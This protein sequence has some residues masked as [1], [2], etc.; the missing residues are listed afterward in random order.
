M[1]EFG[2]YIGRFQPFH[3][4]HLETVRFALKQAKKL[5]IVIGSDNQARTI[6]NPWTS[7]ERIAMMK[8]AISVS[9][10]T[11]LYTQ[12]KVDKDSIEPIASKDLDDVLDR[13]IFI[14]A[15]DYLYN[16]NLWIAAV[17]QAI[18]T[19][20][21]GSKDVVLIGHKKDES[22]FYLKLFPQWKFMETD[23]FDVHCDATKIRDMMF[24][25]DKISFKDR[26]PYYVYNYLIN[27]MDGAEFKRLKEEYDHIARYRA[28]WADAPHPPMFV[29]TDAVVI[30]SGHILVVRRKGAPG[31]GL[32]ALPGGFLQQ[33]E[34]IVDGCIR[35]L[36]EE[37]GIKLPATD[38]K[39]HIVGEH[40][41][42]HPHRSLRGRTI[43]HAFCIKLKD[44]EL[45]IVK[46]MDDADKAWWVPLR[47]IFGHE[48][49]FF[50]DHFHIITYFTH[51]F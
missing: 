45:P 42:D 7:E 6:N 2:I 11:T 12:S 39:T 1:H 20:T 31:Q 19:V 51:R 22:S 17:Q 48:N 38:L 9:A 33:E 43:T 40:V 47:D 13:I 24:M 23:F 32:I 14:T 36:K 3:N 37:T 29:T 8:S 49:E 35:E 16:E 25:Q 28:D 5:I 18:G 15:K 10:H 4:A 21:Q 30:C 50:E 41:F 26:V 44:G 34:K 46:G 27:F